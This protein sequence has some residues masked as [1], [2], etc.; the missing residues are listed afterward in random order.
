MKMA[1]SS[2]EDLEVW[3]VAHHLVLEVYS[4]TGGLP[5]NQRYGPASQMQ[6][7]AVSVPANIAEGFKRRSGAE[8][9]RFYD[10]AQGS[11]EELLYYFILC[12]DLGYKLQLDSLNND[13]QRVGRMLNGLIKSVGRR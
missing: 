13:A 2:F 1:I 12:R 4:I 10:I 7:A 5:P 9:I 3:Q 11:L 8:K 6:R